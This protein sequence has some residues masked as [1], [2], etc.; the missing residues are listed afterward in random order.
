MKH[1][2]GQFVVQQFEMQSLS[3]QPESVLMYVIFTNE[4]EL[5]ILG[6]Y[7]LYLK[8]LNIKYQC[9]NIAVS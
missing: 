2:V 9:F 8:L 4:Q 1:N 6:V 5:M 3:R 7:R